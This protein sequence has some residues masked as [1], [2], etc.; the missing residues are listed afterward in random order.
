MTHETG[1]WDPR[2]ERIGHGSHVPGVSTRN[3]SAVLLRLVDHGREEID[4]PVFRFNQRHRCRPGPHERRPP[5]PSQLTTG[6][7]TVRG[8]RRRPRYT[9][10]VHVV[11]RRRRFGFHL[12]PSR[13]GSPRL[14][15]THGTRGWDPGLEGTGDAVSGPRVRDTR[16]FVD[17][18]II[19]CQRTGGRRRPY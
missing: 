7:T 18:T 13:P 11:H 9:S 15:A 6:A 10:A 16:H 4:T 1:G 5:G 17:P 8:T 14:P 3:T 12:R 2:Q 19:R